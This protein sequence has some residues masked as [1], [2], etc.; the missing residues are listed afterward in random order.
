MQYTKTKMIYYHYKCYTPV[1]GNWKYINT[2][3]KGESLSYGDLRETDSQN[4][5][6]D[7]LYIMPQYMSGGD[8]ANS[9]T[10]EISNHRVFL[11]Q[12]KNVPGV[13]DVGGGYGTF[14]VVIR[15]DVYESNEEIKTIINN[16]D[17]YS[18]IDE[19]DHSNLEMELSN[20]AWDSW[21]RNDMLDLIQKSHPSLENYEADDNFDYLF[22]QASDEANEYWEAEGGDMYIRLEKILPYLKDRLLVRVL[23]QEDLPLLVSY[24]WESDRAH[25]EFEKRLRGEKIE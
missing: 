8:Y 3:K 6:K 19:K 10:V 20:K 17:N 4:Y 13:H 18:L 11:E 23:K 25:E 14:A 7:E 5:K 16:L 9:G 21:A 24:D 1:K 15:V 12:F 2:P 22:Y